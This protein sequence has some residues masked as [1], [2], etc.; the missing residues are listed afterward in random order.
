MKSTKLIIA[1]IIL[2]L[3]V[4]SLL[5]DKP[6]HDSWVDVFT[7]WNPCTE[8]FHEV[9][10][11]NDWYMH[12]HRNNAVF[13]GETTGETDSGYYLNKGKYHLSGNFVNSQIEERFRDTWV[14]ADGSSYRVSFK[15]VYVWATDETRMEDFSLEC[16]D[17]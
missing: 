5:A 10:I 4:S 13:I 17:K 14:A 6:L 11:Y 3:P 16:L 7:E 15:L 2:M 12:F 1:T 9:T 8:Q